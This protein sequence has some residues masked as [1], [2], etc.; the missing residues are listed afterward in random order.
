MLGIE[1]QEIEICQQANAPPPQ[2]K[3]K[4]NTKNY[5]KKKTTKKKQQKNKSQRTNNKRVKRGKWDPIFTFKIHV[6]FSFIHAEGP[7]TQLKF[8]SELMIPCLADS[9]SVVYMNN[10]HDLLG[11]GGRGGAHPP[12]LNLPLV[13]TICIHVLM[14]AIDLGCVQDYRG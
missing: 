1:E 13:I 14:I 2:K 10:F 6:I 9:R 12:H 8:S 4:K 5:K 3:Q 7:W 11:E